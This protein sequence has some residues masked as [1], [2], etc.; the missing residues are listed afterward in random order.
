MLHRLELEYHKPEVSSRK[1]N[2]GQRNAFIENYNTLLNSLGANGAVLFADAVHPAMG[3]GRLLGTQSGPARD[4]TDERA[5]AHQ[6]SWRH[7]R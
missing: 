2:V 6:H 3:V 5:A 7:Q 4:R 1:L